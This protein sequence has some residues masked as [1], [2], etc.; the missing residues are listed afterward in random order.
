MGLP[1]GGSKPAPQLR[2]RTPDPVRRDS[3]SAIEEAAPGWGG[4][5]G[6]WLGGRGGENEEG[7]QGD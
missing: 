3:A 2:K 1:K 5:A 7:E 4:G 6:P